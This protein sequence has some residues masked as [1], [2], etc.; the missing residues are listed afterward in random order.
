MQRSVELLA[1]AG[2]EENFYGAINYGA[3]AVYLGL[4]D[5]SARKNAGNFTFEQLPY[6][7]SYAHIFGVKVYVAINTVIKKKELIKFFEYVQ[8]AYNCGV[9]AFILQDLF[10]GRYLKKMFPQIVLHLSTQAGVNNVD[11]AKQAVAHGFSRVILARETP[12]EEIKKI[13]KIIETEIFIQ[14]A[15]CT[16]FSGHC[17]FSSFIGGNS[18]NRGTCRQPCRKIYKYEGKGITDNFRYALSL[19][20][21]CNASRLKE[22]ISIGVKSF[23]IE[24]RMRSFEY[25]CASCDLYNDILDNGLISR[26]KYENLKKTFNRGGYT[27]GL[28]FGQC[29]NLISDKIQNHAGAVVA[30]VSAIKGGELLLSGLKHSLVEG[31]SFKVITDGCETGHAIAVNKNGKIAVLYREKAFVGSQLAITKSISLIEKYKERFRKVKVDVKVWAIAGQNLKLN[32]NGIDFYSDYVVQESINSAVTKKEI[33]ENLRK[34]DVYPYEV[35][36][37][38]EVQGK[39]FI[40]KKIMNELRSRAYKEYFYSFANLNK[41]TLKNQDLMFDFIDNSV[42]HN[43]TSGVTIIAKD[44]SFKSAINISN[45]VFTPEDYN[46]K[47]QFELFFTQTEKYDAKKYLYVPAFLTEKDE[48]IIASVLSRFDGLYCESASGLFLAK[49]YNKLFFAGIEMNV[50]NH[51]TFTSIQNEGAEE[52]SYSKELSYNEL[53]DLSQNCDGWALHY[54]AIKIM[55]LIYCP[56]NKSCSNCRCSSNFTLKDYSGRDFYVRRYKLSQCRFEVYNDS[57]LNGK[58]DVNKKIFD[59]SFFNA[60][61]IDYLFGVYLGKINNRKF[62]FTSGNLKKGVE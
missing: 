21:L 53:M 12:F 23:K 3:D 25:V 11:G 42:S 58:Y 41:I 46:D 17:Y 54:G 62:N 32:L 44:F 18:G 15:L 22:L 10:L 52:V 35:I 20:D 5:F 6:F 4:S 59:F 13:T 38:C 36:P 29:K 26:L 34:I 27:E 61:Q 31:D 8:K 57:L 14:G 33:K 50:T 45:V 49:R 24:G 43:Q 1:P 30:T 51:L 60:E 19:S 40:P 7:V 55:S 9:D 47:K 2:C 28:T 56:F 48:T 37:S 16:C 39:V